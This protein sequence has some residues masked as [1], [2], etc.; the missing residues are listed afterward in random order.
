MTFENAK[1]AN[2]GKGVFFKLKSVILFCCHQ[3][4][5]NSKHEILQIYFRR[6]KLRCRHK[7]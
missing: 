2:I 6:S 5:N 1:V 7:L 3:I 4:A